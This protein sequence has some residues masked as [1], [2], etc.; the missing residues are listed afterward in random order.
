MNASIIKETNK[1][2]A[3]MWLISLLI[4]LGIYLFPTNTNFTA[5]IRLFLVFVSLIILIIAFN[6]VDVTIA[7]IALPTLFVISG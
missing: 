3:L 1:K 6:L 7:A 5:D 2:S 4:P